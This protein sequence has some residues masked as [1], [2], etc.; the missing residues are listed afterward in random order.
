MIRDG[1]PSIV[2]ANEE[3]QERSS[4]YGEQRWA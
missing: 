3:E 2:N 4:A 1:V